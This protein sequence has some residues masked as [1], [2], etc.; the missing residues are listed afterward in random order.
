MSVISLNQ[1][2]LFDF[3]IKSVRPSKEDLDTIIHGDSIE[4]LKSFA[5]R[6]VDLI[7]T[8]PPY[9]VNLEYGV[10]KDTEENWFKLIEKIIPEILRVSKMAIL[11]C[12]QIAKLPWIYS[13]YPPDWLICWYKGSPG[14]RSFIGFNDWE[15]HLVYGKN[16]SSLTMH[17]FFQT[18]KNI[19]M[20][21]FGHPCPKPLEWATWLIQRA[22]CEGDLVCDPFS[23]SGTVAVA[24]HKLRRHY[25]GIDID[26]KYVKI[27]RERIAN[28][29][30]RLDQ[31]GICIK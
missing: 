18:T 17:D 7:V 2:T 25:I 12:C 24:A 22:S 20:G 31:M 28:I 13:K 8:D 1:K 11:P 4:V 10:Y 21:S 23:G 29:P 27:A 30:L 16:R 9:G 3:Q 5:D 6:S 15:P 19:P 26:A 14:H